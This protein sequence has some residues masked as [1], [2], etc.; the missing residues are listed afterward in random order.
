MQ[1]GIGGAPNTVG[2]NRSIW[3]GRISRA[4]FWGIGVKISHA[5]TADLENEILP[6]LS[7]HAYNPAAKIVK[8]PVDVVPTNQPSNEG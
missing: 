8:P 3:P 2:T 4:S 5:R 6:F 1:A 7:A